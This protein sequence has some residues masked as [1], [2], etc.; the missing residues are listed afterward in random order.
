MI[1][2]KNNDNYSNILLEL[3]KRET[4]E[5]TSWI[6]K[7]VKES[8][9]HELQTALTN[10]SEEVVA[11]MKA[12][13]EVAKKGKHGSE[14]PKELSKSIFVLM[15]KLSDDID[16]IYDKSLKS[17]SILMRSFSAADTNCAIAII[18]DM[19]AVSGKA[20]AYLVHSGLIMDPT[21]C[22]KLNDYLAAHTDALTTGERGI[23]EPILRDQNCLIR[24]VNA[25]IETVA[26]L[27]QDWKGE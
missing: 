25:Y 16:F 23:F 27:D 18:A 5:F 8:E 17:Q 15:S 2:F 3:Q 1:I 13:T 10:A 4:D 11:T 20:K 21:K 26:K 24:H 12:V 7:N 19:A 9:L 22:S 6:I 14:V